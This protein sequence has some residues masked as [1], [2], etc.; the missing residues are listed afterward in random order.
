[1]QAGQ[2]I[3]TPLAGAE[4]TY[5]GARSG[6]T[7]HN[8]I[9][10]IITRMSS[11]L[12]DRSR[13]PT[14]PYILLYYTSIKIEMKRI[15]MVNQQKGVQQNT[16]YSAVVVNDLMYPRPCLYHFFSCFY[17]FWVKNDIGMGI[18]NY[19]HSLQLHYRQYLVALLFGDLPSLSPF[20]S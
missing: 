16:A 9:L 19:D 18:H 13:S 1:M 11:T 14:A 7:L 12:L 15:G 17:P 3:Y 10:Y 6:F 8:A 20:I 4:W 2:G 5:V